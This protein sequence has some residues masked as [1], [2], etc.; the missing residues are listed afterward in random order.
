MPPVT[1]VLR[2]SGGPTASLAFS[3]ESDQT[4][5]QRVADGLA[6]VAQRFPLHP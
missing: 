3:F 5:M 2:D 6:E 4:F 1:G